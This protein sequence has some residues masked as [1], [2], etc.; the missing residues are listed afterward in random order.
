MTDAGALDRR[1]VFLVLRQVGPLGGVFSRDALLLEAAGLRPH[2]T[3]VSLEVVEVGLVCERLAVARETV[4]KSSFFNSS[5][6]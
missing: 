2:I 1:E 3:K 5:R 4:S 6:V